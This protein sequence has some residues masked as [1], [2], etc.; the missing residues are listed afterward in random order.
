MTVSIGG[1]D[2]SQSSI[3]PSRTSRI[4]KLRVPNRY[5]DQKQGFGSESYEAKVTGVWTAYDPRPTIWGYQL[6]N[7][8][9]Q[10]VLTAPDQNEDINHRYF[11]IRSFQP[12]LVQGIPTSIMITFTMDLTEAI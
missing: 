10:L 2:I 12:D 3:K 8:P 4:G 5:G 9:V 7:T 6:N 1:I 11:L